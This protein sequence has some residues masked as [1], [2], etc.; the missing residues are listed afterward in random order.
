MKLNFDTN[1]YLNK[2][3]E[4]FHKKVE[5]EHKKGWLKL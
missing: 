2:Y 1:N 4:I 3:L 5:N